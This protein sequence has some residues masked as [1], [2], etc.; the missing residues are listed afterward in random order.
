MAM[1]EY[2]NSPFG[3]PLSGLELMDWVWYH[4]Q[5]KTRHTATA[6]TLTSIFNLDKDKYYML[7]KHG[8]EVKIV[9]VERQDA[10]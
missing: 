8:K 9:E 10:E 7:E 6:K 4:S 3:Q 2:M 1:A 5:N